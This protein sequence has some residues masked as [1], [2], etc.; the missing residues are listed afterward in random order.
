MPRDLRP[1]EDTSRL[2]IPRDQLARFPIGSV[3][4]NVTPYEGDYLQ[5]TATGEVGTQGWVEFALVKEF[6][7]DQDWRS[8]HKWGGNPLA[9]PPPG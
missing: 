5:V 3:W 7:G 1:L 8:V 2:Y 6:N 9:T 4:E